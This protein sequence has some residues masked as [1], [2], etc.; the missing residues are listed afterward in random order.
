MKFWK[1]IT[2]HGFFGDKPKTIIWVDDTKALKSGEGEKKARQRAVLLETQNKLLAT[3]ISVLL[4]EGVGDFSRDNC[5]I[6]SE[7]VAGMWDL[8]HLNIHIVAD[9]VRIPLKRTLNFYQWLME[10]FKGHLGEE[11]HNL[12]LKNLDPILED[13]CDLMLHVFSLHTDFK[14]RVELISKYKESNEYKMA[15]HRANSMALKE[16]LIT[17]LSDK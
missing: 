16:K 10:E 11:T 7:W 6:M 3:P 17:R 1:I 2:E 14:T 13:V 8:N 12:L 4:M 15:L 5:P 9:D